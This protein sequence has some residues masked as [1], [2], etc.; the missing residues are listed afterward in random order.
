MR[1]V[2]RLY[3]ILLR[4]YPCAFRDEFADEMYNVF[5]N[6]V[7][8]A[9]ARDLNSLATLCLRELRDLPLSIL[10]EH[11]RERR[12]MESE[13]TSLRAVLAS[14]VPFLVFLPHSEKSVRVA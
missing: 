10:R 1:F 2:I 8:E 3:A 4:L 9:N 7:S 13:S 14:I 6:A 5:A 12:K 11:W